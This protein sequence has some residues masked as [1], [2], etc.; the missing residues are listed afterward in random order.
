MVKPE[1]DLMEA[2]RHKLE[3]L[4]AERLVKAGEPCVVCGDEGHHVDHD[5]SAEVRMVECVWT[6]PTFKGDECDGNRSHYCDR[7]DDDY[8]ETMQK[9]DGPCQCEC[10]SQLLRVS[11]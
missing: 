8:D 4:H 6:W 3:E 9:H 2:L 5:T 1:S 10:G 7:D 11:A